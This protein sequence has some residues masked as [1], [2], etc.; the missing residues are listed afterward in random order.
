MRDYQHMATWKLNDETL[1]SILWNKVQIKLQKKLGEI[2]DGSV[3][4]IQTL[5]RAEMVI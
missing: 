5:L 2:S 1:E 3:Q 4:E